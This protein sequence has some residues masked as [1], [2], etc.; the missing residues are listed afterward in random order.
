MA[1]ARINIYPRVGKKFWGRKNLLKNPANPLFSGLFGKNWWTVSISGIS[2]SPFRDGCRGWMIAAW[3]G[4]L[5]F[6]FPS[7][8]GCKG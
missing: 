1:R 7:S 4:Y 6:R 5:P 2:V 3:T 8:P